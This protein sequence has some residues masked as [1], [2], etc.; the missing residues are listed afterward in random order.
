[1]QSLPIN[2]QD[3]RLGL[4]GFARAAYVTALVPYAV[5]TVAAVTNFVLAFL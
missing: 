1:M 2:P 5:A 4:N 3:A